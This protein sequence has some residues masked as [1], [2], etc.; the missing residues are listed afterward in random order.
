M[1]KLQHALPFLFLSAC[2]VRQPAPHTWRLANRILLPPGVTSPDLAARTITAPSTVSRLPCP[3]TDALTLQ[4]RRITVHRE[5]LLRQPPGWLAD[6]IDH[7]IPAAQA[8][9]LTARILESLPLPSG[10]ALRLLRGDGRQNFVELI[11][12]SRLQVVS[13]VLGPPPTAPQTDSPMK[14]T[15]Q[16]YSLQVEMQAPPDL[17]GFEIAW[18]DL[19]PKPDGRGSL[20]VPASAQINIRGK[21]EDRP[22]PAVNLFRFPPEIAFYRLFYK[23]DQSEILALSPTR[24]ALPTDPDACATC[25]PIP[26]G[27][28]VNPYMHVEVNGAPVSVGIGATVRAALQ[29]AKQRP[30][31]ALPTLTITKPFAGRPVNM[32]FDR[33]TPDILNLSLTGDEQIRFGR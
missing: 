2:A 4:R 27:V 5:A 29:A 15:G 6:W 18:Y 10:A 13:P 8:P 12:G 16:G 20:I 32:E 33:S 24:A 30:E 26:R 11:A 25:F 22:A 9:L 14:V 3:P 23:A 1:L 7:C 19:V 28:G 31:D 17:I 21:V